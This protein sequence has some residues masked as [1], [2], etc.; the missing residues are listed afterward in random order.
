[1][2]C[3]K[4]GAELKDGYVYCPICGQEAQIVS[5]VSILEDELLQDLMDEQLHP[6]ADKEKK[7]DPGQDISPE[8][9]QAQKREERKR[10]KRRKKRIRMLVTLIAVLAAAL[11]GVFLAVRYRQ[12]HSANYLLTKAQEAYTQKNYQRAI[13]WLEKLLDLDGDN[14]DGLLLS[15]R[16][17]AAG[18]DYDESEMLYLQVLDLDADNYEAY[19][20]L[21]AIYDAQDRTDFI[22]ALMEDVTDPEILALFEDYIIPTPEISVE[23]GSYSEFF[24]VRITAEKKTLSIYYTLDGSAPSA[25][26]TLYTEPIE[27]NEQGTIT[28]TAVCADEDGNLSEP[29]TAVYEVA[30]DSP[31]TPTVSPDS[32]QFTSPVSITVTVPS[33]ITVY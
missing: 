25:D 32:G 2:V 16:I 29:V 24:A 28:L 17:D 8:K 22:L 14:I 20:G 30:L 23:S 4:C 15:A 11:I 5:D 10:E 3:S 7:K 19:E 21:I 12:N 1:M 27:I 33:G 6:D 9:K 26:D 13:N 18:K 31:D